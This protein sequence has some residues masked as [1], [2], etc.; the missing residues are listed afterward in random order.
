MKDIKEKI[1][2]TLVSGCR[3]ADK[4]N[5]Y[6][7]NDNIIDSICQLVKE[8]LEE[9]RE[10]TISLK[11]DGVDID[12]L[13]GYIFCPCGQTLQTREAVHAH[14][15]HLG[16]DNHIR[17]KTLDEISSLIEKKINKLKGE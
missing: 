11:K 12:D 9:L 2:R 10:E 1:K 17:S 16:H 7:F 5:G 4:G 15:E 13:V 14:K 6:F 8:E 3:P